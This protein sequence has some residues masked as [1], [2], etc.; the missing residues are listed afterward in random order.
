[1]S[2]GHLL[3]DLD[4]VLVDSLPLIERNWRTWAAERRLDAD[5]VFAGSHGRRDIDVVR[6]VAPHLDAEAEARAIAEREERDFA[7]L[8]PIPGAAALLG[9]VPP[10]RWAVV[11]SAPRAVATGRLGA[12]SL[13][14]PDCLVAAEDIAAGKPDPEGYLKAAGVLGADPAGCV[15][16]EDA[17][18][19]MEAARAAGMRCVG[20]GAEAIAAPDGILAAAVED[21]SRV[22][23][24]VL[25]GGLRI[26]VAD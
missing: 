21:L 16:F 13:P 15:V 20:V 24:T 23:V 18:A 10:G 22:R 25:S 3:F 9:A 14:T 5:L 12:V 11:T 7:G 2:C 4:G 1:M 17:R 26:T 19:G 6:L 8:R